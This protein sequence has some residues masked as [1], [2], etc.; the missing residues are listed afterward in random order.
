MISSCNGSTRYLSGA[1]LG[2]ILGSPAIPLCL[3]CRG[4]FP[5]DYSLQKYEHRNSTLA[6]VGN[7]SEV[8]SNA[9]NAV[10]LNSPKITVFTNGPLTEAVNQSILAVY[11]DAFTLLA[12]EGIPIDQRTIMR[13]NQITANE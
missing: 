6:V 10:A 4:T 3:V 1:R 7:N 5:Q 11:P 2:S 8:I 12:A 9:L 13:L